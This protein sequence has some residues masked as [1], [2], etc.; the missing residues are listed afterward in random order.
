MKD[1]SLTITEYHPAHGAPA[2]QVVQQAV[3]A[4]LTKVLH[5]SYAVGEV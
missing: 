4:W 1:K 3:I 5:S 2:G